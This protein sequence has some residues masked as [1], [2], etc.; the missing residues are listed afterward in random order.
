MPRQGERRT[1]AA[2]K[3]SEAD[4]DDLKAI[5]A[6]AGIAQ[7]DVVRAGIELVLRG[8]DRDRL[9]EYLVDVGR[10]SPSGALTRE[11]WVRLVG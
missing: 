8:V 3:V 5:A 10:E 1:A 2:T 6:A 9:L 11:R 7:S 4:S